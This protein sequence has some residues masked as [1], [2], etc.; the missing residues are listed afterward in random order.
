MAIDASRISINEAAKEKLN[1]FLKFFDI[2]IDT[3][4][5][6]IAPKGKAPR[7]VATKAI[8][9]YCSIDNDK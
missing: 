2:V 8:R 7:K 9:K 3:T 4:D 6:F 5:K 1:P